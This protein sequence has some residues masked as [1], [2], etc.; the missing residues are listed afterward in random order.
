MITVLPDVALLAEAVAEAEA[1]AGE[2]S[3]SPKTARLVAM[4]MQ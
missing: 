3:C 1:G 2:D 4:A